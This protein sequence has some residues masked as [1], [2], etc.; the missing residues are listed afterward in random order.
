V[1]NKR[2]RECVEGREV[3]KKQR[4]RTLG[5]KSTRFEENLPCY[6]K[7]TRGKEKKD[8]GRRQNLIMA[9][10]LERSGRG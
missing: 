8:S 9:I 1:E 5:Q 7:E 10:L 3:G 2:G 6:C 4:D